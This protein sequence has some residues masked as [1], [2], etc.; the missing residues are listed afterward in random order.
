MRISLYSVTLSD[1]TIVY[2]RT[3]G[4]VNARRIVTGRLAD[5]KAPESGLKLTVTS[6]R[7]VH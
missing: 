4:M 1:D 6:I 7:K 2:V 5:R 3:T